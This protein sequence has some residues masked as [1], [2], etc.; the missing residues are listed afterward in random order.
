[1][2][3]NTT[4]LEVEDKLVDLFTA[5]TSVP[6]TYA[7]PGPATRSTCV[8]L[9]V[10]PEAQD[11]LLDLT[12]EDPV[13]KSGRRQSQEEY[14]LPVT[15]WAFRP[16]LSADG[17]RDCSGTAHAI[18][19]DLYDVLVD[20]VKLGLGSILWA[21]PDGFERRLYPFEKGWACDFRFYVAVNARIT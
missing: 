2:A 9:G 12:S 19:D 17:A 21:R 3:T 7:W 14:R 8:F 10:H 16:D 18:F 11:I 4:V 20:N 15:I 5:A 1:M 13:I 6:V